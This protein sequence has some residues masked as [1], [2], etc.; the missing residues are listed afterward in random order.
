[1]SQKGNKIS[2][3]PMKEREISLKVAGDDGNSDGVGDGDGDGDGDN[4]G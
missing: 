4:D 2:G 3:K 1:M